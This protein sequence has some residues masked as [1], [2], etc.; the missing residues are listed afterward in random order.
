MRL[1]SK[2]FAPAAMAIALGAAVLS[3]VLLICRTN[4]YADISEVKIVQTTKSDYNR[5]TV[6][7][8][9][10][11]KILGAEFVVPQE[12]KK[13]EDGCVMLLVQ[14]AKGERD[15][16]SQDII[17]EEMFQEI[18]PELKKHTYAFPGLF[19]RKT[20]TKAALDSIPLGISIEAMDSLLYPTKMAYIENGLLKADYSKMQIFDK[21]TGKF[22]S[23]Y[24]FFKNGKYVSNELHEQRTHMNAWLLKFLPGIDW[25]YDHNILNYGF[26]KKAFGRSQLKKR[27]VIAT[28]GDGHF[29]RNLM[30]LV[31]LVVFFVVI[32]GFNVFIPMLPAYTFYGLLTFPPVFKAFNRTLTDIVVIGLTVLSYYYIWL[33][34]M[35]YMSFFF[36]PILMIPAAMVAIRPLLDRDDICD[37]CKYM[38]TSAFDHEELLGEYDTERDE[39]STSKVGSRITGRRQTWDN[40]TH[41]TK[42][43]YSGRII[44]QYTN[45]TNIKNYTDYEDTYKTD[46]YHRKYHIKVYK[47]YYKCEVCG[48]IITFERKDS[49]LL[50]SQHLGSHTHTT[51]R[52]VQH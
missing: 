47:D 10:I 39:S 21:S 33:T 46:Q 38:N 32:F 35:P 25:V 51:S 40:I 8:G 23:L 7:K 12:H 19:C 31:L 44:S 4:E 34:Y 30:A 3:F 28:F 2:G 50:S 43:A 9:E 24:V 20:M 41:T 37:R 42:N 29:L 27:A 26:S 17:P 14:T 36:M 45:K 49:T 11:V 1:N 13:G 52:T 5:F 18:L 16:I 6:R 15:L 48:T 22:S